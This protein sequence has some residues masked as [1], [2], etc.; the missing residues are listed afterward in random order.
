MLIYNER[1]LLKKGIKDAVWMYF[2][3][4]KMSTFFMREAKSESVK[5]LFCTQTLLE[6]VVND[7]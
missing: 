2:V 7:R 4:Q 5:S 6:I 3:N 1:K